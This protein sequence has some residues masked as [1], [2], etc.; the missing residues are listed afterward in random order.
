MVL[1]WRFELGFWTV[2]S[3]VRVEGADAKGIEAALR[4]RRSAFCDVQLLSEIAAAGVGAIARCVR[5]GTC[6]GTR[7]VQVPADRICGDAKSRTS[8]DERAEERDAVDGAADVE[9]ESFAEHSKA[10]E[11]SSRANGTWV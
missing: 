9:A 2:F 4:Q 5:K 1:N 11:K 8:V 6:S 3:R 10:R 7:R